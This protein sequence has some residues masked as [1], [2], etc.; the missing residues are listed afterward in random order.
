M[1]ILYCDPTIHSS[2]SDNYKYYDGVFDE[3]VKMKNCDVFLHRGMIT[4][5]TPAETQFDAI[6]F[7]LGWF[8]HKFYGEIKN[9][10][11]P[12]VC[13]LFKPQNDFGDKLDFCKINKVDRILT[14]VPRVSEYREATG[15]E[16]V[17]FPYGYCPSTFHPRRD[18]EQTTDVGFSGALH[19]N[20]HYPPESFL[21]ENLRTKVGEKLNL[22]NKVRVFW[23]SS[24]DR[25]S[26]I[27]GYE[28]YARK[29]NS[30]KIWI[31]TS[32]AFGDIT[33]RYY[34]VLA[35]GTLLFCQKIP[36]D[37][38]HI[39]ISGE[40]CV[41]F[42]S[43]LSDFEENLEKYIE[44]DELRKSVVTRAVSDSQNHTWKNRADEILKII[45]SIV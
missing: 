42:A 20:K 26:R 38:R 12:S 19:E 37:Y 18:V 23:N 36:D 9:L 11:I 25:P 1:R 2:T 27:P 15:I 6:V 39:F 30:S 8:N 4:D 33:P 5:M 14:P 24:D 45:G 21:V 32:A 41:E 43:D 13:I 29:I 16:T 31:A 10:N 3:L 22:M 34:E 35:S 40:N 17:L 7:G 44:D 28:D